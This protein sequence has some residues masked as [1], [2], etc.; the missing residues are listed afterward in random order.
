MTIIKLKELAATD[1][2]LAS[3]LNGAHTFERLA[4]IANEVGIDI[5]LDELEPLNTELS[6]EELS[7]VSGGV[8]ALGGVGMK[9]F[10]AD[11]AHSCDTSTCKECRS[12]G[13]HSCDTKAG[14]TCCSSC[15]TSSGTKLSFF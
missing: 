9:K 12:C 11:G 10:L 5:T 13:A 2:E 14:N 8:R 15:G 6:E 7:E 1:T 3:K 4:H